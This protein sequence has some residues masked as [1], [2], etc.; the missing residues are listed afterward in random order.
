M[1][2]RER[3]AALAES[4]SV[5]RAMCDMRAEAMIIGAEMALEE[6]ARECAMYHDERWDGYKRGHGPGRANPEWQGNANGA[7]VCEARIRALA[8]GLDDKTEIR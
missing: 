5:G 8:E 1:S 6:A 7:A 4:T 2:L 3:L